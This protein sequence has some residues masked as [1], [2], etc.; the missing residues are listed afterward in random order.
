MNK[1]ILTAAVVAVAAMA[2][3]SALERYRFSE[4]VV[5]PEVDL[6]NPQ[7]SCVLAP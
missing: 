1:K 5:H 2:T 4:R 6:T 3:Y 7:I